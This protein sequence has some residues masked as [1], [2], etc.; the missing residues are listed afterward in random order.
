MTCLREAVC[1]PIS[2]SDLTR[3]S[4]VAE[5][6]LTKHFL[7]FIG[8]SPMRY[9]QQLRLAGARNTLLDAA[10][11]VSVTAVAKEYCF[12]HQGRFA[13]RY[14]RAFGESPSA[15]LRRGQ[16]GTQPDPAARRVGSSRARGRYDTAA[17]T[18]SRERPSIA[19]L[20]CQVPS[21]EP[22][23][24]WLAES[25][26]DAVAG[27]LCS[28]R[29]LAVTAPMSLRATARDPQRIA[30]ELSA[31]YVLSG[32]VV[33]TGARLRFV[34]S[35][36]DLVTE[37]HVW[38]DSFDGARDDPLALQDRIVA[39]MARSILPRIRGAEIARAQRTSLQT[40]DPYSLVMRALPLV[41]A[42]RPDATRRALDLL[43][44]A[45]EFDPD[46]GLAIALAAWGHSQLVMYNGTD[47]PAE[48]KAHSL[49]LVQRAETLESDDPLVLTARCAVYTMVREF[50][51][52]EAM[53][54]RALA[55][56]PTFGW[57]WG[58]SAWLH[59]YRGD[60]KTAIEHFNQA[61]SLDPDSV[62]RTNSF[63]G[64]G[65]AY[66]NAE[67]YQAAA[68]WLRQALLEQPGMWWANRS[69]SVSYARLGERPKALDS[70]DALRRSCPDLTVGR[71]VAS[72]PFTSE[73]L[74]RLGEGLSDLGLPP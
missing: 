64:L 8:V 72:V 57:A 15:T 12:N 26:A 54:T 22:Q 9:L 74:D 70:L 46:Y 29:T 14:R 20:P 33:Y 45:I 17:A 63:V 16:A 3:H 28:F 31:R 44:R 41:F 24:R 27:A 10:P 71:I 2:M 53:V 40:L 37:H 35:L 47:A 56:D 25:V 59:S 34:L 39:G 49:Q 38:G 62:C 52:A 13:E 42:S 66:F 69:L 67:S 6:T 73:F 48:E 50:D 1:R 18:R 11:G 51:A 60:S 61:L 7:T 19:V 58:R 21:S 68:F 36:V 23:L 43:H 4:G 30:R 32:R 65:S 55:L 5:R